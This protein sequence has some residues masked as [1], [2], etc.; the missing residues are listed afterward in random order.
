MGQELLSRGLKTI[1]TLW[2]ASAILQDNYHELV[3]DIHLDYINAGC[4]VIIT[5]TFSTRKQKLIEND[6]AHKFEELNVKACEIAINA[7]EKNKHILIA[8]GLPPQNVVYSADNRSDEEILDN[9]YDQAKIINP[10]VD[11]FFFEVLSSF[12]E[13]K[14]ATKAIES[15]KKPYL[16]GLHIS[17]G[18]QLP[19]GEKI[20]AL[21]ENLQINEALG[22]VLSCVSPENYLLNS[23]ILRDFESPFGFKLNGFDFTNPKLGYSNIYNS[24]DIDNPNLILGKRQDLDPKKFYE[25]S[26][27]FKNL[28]ATILGGCCETSPA[29]IKEIVKL[30]NTLA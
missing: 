6:L 29:H 28:G 15:F 18:K 7:K 2:S 22:V 1:G 24:G 5:T 10:F 26:K 21:N 23:K 19:S 12:R 8:G 4:D 16:L 20:A 11:F 30:R 17:E 9:Y 27:T 3:E 14:L 25:F 13:A